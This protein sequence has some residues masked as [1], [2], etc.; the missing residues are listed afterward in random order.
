MPSDPTPDL[1]MIEACLAIARREHLLDPVPL[2]LGTDHLGERDLGTRVGQR[3]VRARLADRTDHHQSLL[4]ADPVLLLGTDRDR[5][6]I[7][8]ERPLL[9]VA[10]G[11]PL[12]PRLRLAVGPD[13]G[14]HERHFSLAAASGVTT[15][16]ATTLQVAHRRVAGHVQDVTLLPRPQR[17]P[18][19]RSPAQFVIA[20]DPAM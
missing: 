1:V 20:R 2:S 15:P 19:L 14:P 12:P 17:R 10:D 16:R 7:D 8:D 9:T 4:R 18:E 6:G 11:D 13:V 3:I 5:H